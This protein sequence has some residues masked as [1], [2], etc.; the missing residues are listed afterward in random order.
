MKPACV[1][2]VQAAAAAMGR[3]KALTAGE[4]ADI[5]GL[6]TGAITGVIDRLEK[7]G[8]AERVRD[9]YDR[10]KVLIQPLNSPK[11]EALN[12]LFDPLMQAMTTLMERYTEQERT[13]IIDFVQRSIMILQDETQRLRAEDE[14]FRKQ[15]QPDG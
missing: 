5:T 3:A 6:T 13:A 10:R 11:L 2:A 7:A 1:K 15:T 12:G 4:L 8:Y 14:L 9:A